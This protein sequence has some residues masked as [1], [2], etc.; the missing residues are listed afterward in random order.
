MKTGFA[1]KCTLW[2]LTGHVLPTLISSRSN[3]ARH[4]NLLSSAISALA[5]HSVWASF[6]AFMRGQNASLQSLAA[7]VLHNVISLPRNNGSCPEVCVMKAKLDCDWQPRL[8]CIKLRDTWSHSSCLVGGDGRL[9][10]TGWKVEGHIPLQF[11]YDKDLLIE[12]SAL[13]SCVCRGKERFGNMPVLLMIEG[14]RKETVCTSRVRGSLPE[15]QKDQTCYL[16]LKEN[17]MKGICLPGLTELEQQ[18]CFQAG[19]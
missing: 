3:Y 11:I 4:K 18:P 15:M 17:C 16:W 6:A 14:Y 13:S 1:L 5:F 9:V 7:D 19:T 12:C 10:M 2:L 8:C